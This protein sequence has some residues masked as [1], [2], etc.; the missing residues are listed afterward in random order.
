MIYL[1]LKVVK[2]AFVSNVLT[3]LGYTVQKAENSDH[4]RIINGVKVEIKGSTLAK[5][6]KTFSVLSSP[7]FLAEGTAI[8]DLENPDRVLIG[9]EDNDAIKSLSNIIFLKLLITAVGLNSAV[10]I[11][12]I[13]Y[14]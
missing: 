6:K 3:K 12:M 4:D 13:K 2:I 11:F 7:E 9:G 10:F 5:N 1:F 14:Y 8:N